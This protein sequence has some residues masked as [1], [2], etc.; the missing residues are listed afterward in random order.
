MTSKPKNLA[1]TNSLSTW[2]AH[3]VK[4]SIPI[5]HGSLG[6][7]PVEE[8]FEAAETIARNAGWTD[9]QKKTFFTDR[10]QKPARDFH[11]TLTAAQTADYALWKENFSAGF[12]DATSKQRALTKLENLKQQP[13]E[14]VRDFSKNINTAY[15]NAHG[16]AAAT[17]ADVTVAELRSQTMR[18]IFLKGLK[19]EIYDML[20]HRILPAHTYD[21]IVEQATTI[22]TLVADKK[23][24]EESPDVADALSAIAKQSEKQTIEVEKLREQMEKLTIKNS[25]PQE[26]ANNLVAAFQ[27]DQY[28]NQQRVRFSDNFNR[29]PPDR[30][31]ERSRSPYRY[32]YSYGP[33]NW[34]T[35]SFDRSPAR[36]GNSNYQT[37]RKS[38]YRNDR[39]PPKTCYYCNNR[40]HIAKDCRKRMYEKDS[41]RTPPPQQTAPRQE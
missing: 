31:R 11:D 20:W 15:K 41:R 26:G 8:W 16:N 35:R 32:N 29:G 5:F 38:T 30:Q 18:K 39:P 27:H 14:R 21:E 6:D 22:E 36:Y 28:R 40:G 3:V 2:N 12:T 34:G 7:Q 37:N 19:K 10:I 23:R 9:D 13:N 17:S 4:Q 33:T 1:L 24:S 25:S